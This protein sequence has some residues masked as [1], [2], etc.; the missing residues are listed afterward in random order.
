VSFAAGFPRRRNLQPR[1]SHDSCTRF[2]SLCAIE[3]RA[4]HH[5]ADL[6]VVRIQNVV[7]KSRAWIVVLRFRLRIAA[8]ELPMEERSAII[9]AILHAFHDAASTL[10]VGRDQHQF[11]NASNTPR[12]VE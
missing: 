1:V 5:L 7:L 4:I 10:P 2:H 11:H 8:H 3:R 6:G 9:F 12:S